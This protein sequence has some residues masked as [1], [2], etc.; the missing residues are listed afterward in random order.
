MVNRKATAA[1][2]PATAGGIKRERM[3]DKAALESWGAHHLIHGHLTAAYLL[4]SASPQFKMASHPTPP[5]SPTPFLLRI[6]HFLRS[7]V[8]VAGV[9]CWGGAATSFAY[10]RGPRSHNLRNKKCTTRDARRDVAIPLATQT[11]HD[12]SATE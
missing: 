11:L 7:P 2:Q 10:V 8:R 5:S 6:P 4:L 3:L 12:G 9:G 1:A